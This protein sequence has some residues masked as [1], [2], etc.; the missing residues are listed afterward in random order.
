MGLIIGVDADGV[1][2]NLYEFNKRTGIE[3]FKKD[4]VN[5]AGYSARE[6]FDLTKNQ[7][8]KHTAKYFDQYCKN[9]TPR[10]GCVDALN[11][12]F[13][14]GLELHS[15]TARLFTTNKVLGKR[16]QKFFKEWLDKNKLNVFKSIQFCSGKMT[17]RDK[18]I[19]CKKLCVDIMIDD[20]PEVSMH[21][22][23]NGIKVAL[24]DAPYN[25]DVSHENI[26]RCKNYEDI[27]SCINFMKLSKKATESK[28]EDSKDSYFINYYNL[29]KSMPFEQEKFEANK[30]LYHKSYPKM[31]KNTMQGFHTK[32]I[33]E[34]NI[35]FQDGMIILANKTSNIDKYSICYALNNRF[36][37]IYDTTEDT[38]S[39][40]L[41]AEN[42][43]TADISEK[44]G[45][46]DFSAKLVQ[47]S[48][49]IIFDKETDSDT[50]DFDVNIFN[51]AQLAKVPIL[52]V[53]I[54]KKNK[55]ARATNVIFGEAFFVEISDDL[56]TVKTNTENLIK[57][58]LA[59]N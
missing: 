1:L 12:F 45:K 28:L 53:A 27:K 49:C 6:M 2:T 42:I 20:S 10:E 52:P 30:K 24:V 9:E 22:A 59:N 51:C 11:L 3:M 29:L 35:V 32:V 31:T 15:I 13:D 58:M 8:I 34:E 18:L 26:I 48:T 38:Y 33:N 44:Q 16:Y 43:V 25:K 7:E 47:G 57:N 5:T 23:K 21:L 4:V 37:T 55:N 40:R 41:F 39:D 19:A 46:T 50:I 54:S 17:N 14:E 56:Q 36:V